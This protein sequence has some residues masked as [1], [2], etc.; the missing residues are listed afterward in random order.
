MGDHVENKEQ[1]IDYQEV[2]G[3]LK[4]VALKWRHHDGTLNPPADT[5][6]STASAS[7]VV[8]LKDAALISASAFQTEAA[9]VYGTW[10]TTRP[11]GWKA[12]AHLIMAA[13]PTEIAIP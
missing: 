1:T 4:L 7:Q 2:N 5:T 13:L 3:A 10:W 6:S 8:D 11:S 9:S 12:H